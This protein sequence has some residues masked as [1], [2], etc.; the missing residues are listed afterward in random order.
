MTPTLSPAAQAEL[1]NIARTHLRLDTLETQKSDRLDFQEHSVGSIKAAL[2]A[3][4]LAGVTDH[5]R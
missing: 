2:E 4:Y 5:H 1:V 3:A